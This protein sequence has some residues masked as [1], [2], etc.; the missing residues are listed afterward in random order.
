M[1]PWDQSA[2]ADKSWDE[3]VSWTPSSGMQ[4]VHRRL[5]LGHHVVGGVAEVA[6]VAGDGGVA[7][8]G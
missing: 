8:V 3:G 6:E 4:Y 5:H 2:P 7:E 1:G